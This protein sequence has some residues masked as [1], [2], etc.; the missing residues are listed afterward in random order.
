M[1]VVC[2]VSLGSCSFFNYGTRTEDLGEGKYRVLTP[3]SW[4]VAAEN[5][6][7][8]QDACP[9]GYKILKRGTRPDSAFNV[10]FLGSDFATYWIVQCAAK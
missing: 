4:D 10:A 5:D 9:D 8:S 1:L 2:V 7:A 6:K 3:E